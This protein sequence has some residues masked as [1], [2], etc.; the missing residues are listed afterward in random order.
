MKGLVVFLLLVV[1]AL[2]AMAQPAGH[3][4]AATGSRTVSQVGM[5]PT[6]MVGVASGKADT[7]LFAF[8]TGALAAFLLVWAP[9][10][11]GWRRRAGSRAELSALILA[12][13]LCGILAVEGCGS[14]AAGVAGSD[15]SH[16]AQ[17]F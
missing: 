8:G 12:L 6:A 11:G 1:C 2:C 10:G 4:A 15:A 17:G 5:T 13:L 14:G 9:I 3:P 16:A 7:G